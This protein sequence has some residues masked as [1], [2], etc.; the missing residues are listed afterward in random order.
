MIHY[1]INQIA[2]VIPHLNELLEKY[3]NLVNPL[4]SY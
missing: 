4:S 1:F 2:A 3:D